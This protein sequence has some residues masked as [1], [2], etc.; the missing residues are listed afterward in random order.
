MITEKMTT[1]ARPYALAAFEYALANSDLAGWE[2]ML[3]AAA[4]VAQDPQVV[5]LLDSPEMT[6]EQS[7]A[8][9]CDVLSKIL[10]TEKTNFIR[11]LAS[12]ERLTVL[13]GILDLFIAYRENYEKTVS[14][15]I[16]SAIEL[17]E[18]YK[19]RVAKALSERLKRKVML[20]SKID[21][22]LLG[23]AIVRAGD[24][25]IDGSIRGKLNRLIEFI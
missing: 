10:N 15:E 5:R 12:Y 17:N 20:H 16:T 14:V 24:L 9:F 13:P 3:R 4:R 2:A 1:L 21:E 6:N 22:T 25:V 18:L 23:G 8:L 11:L 19:E 7:A